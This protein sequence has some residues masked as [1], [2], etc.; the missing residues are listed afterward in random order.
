M[1]TFPDPAFPSPDSSFEGAG[2]AC[3]VYGLVPA[4]TALPSDAA[5]V[6]HPAAPITLVVHDAVAAVVSEVSVE[7][8]LGTPED[9]R[10]HA[11]VLDGLAASTTVLP[12]RFGTVVQDVRSVVEELLV[13][14]DKEF[15]AGLAELEGKAQFTLR[16]RYEEDAILREL[17]EE[18]P[19]I[20]RL[21]EELAGLSEEV[22]YHRRIRL[23]ELV[24]D[25]LAGKREADGALILERLAPMVEAVGPVEAGAGDMVADAS[26][27]VA[28]DRQQDFEKAADHLARDLHGRVRLRL[29]GPLAPYDFVAE[30]M[31]NLEWGRS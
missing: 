29:L 13:G 27:L 3:Y 18:R 20:V 14:H 10:A 1:T 9:L 6:G 12:F 26:F 16:A 21:R 23:G 30:V 28:L 4:D 22:A 24:A 31:D 17:L 15:S 5:G 25:G 7:Q 19:D 2:F 11:R 8:P